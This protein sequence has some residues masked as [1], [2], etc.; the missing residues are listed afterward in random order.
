MKKSR[1]RK[2]EEDA[3]FIVTACNMHEELVEAL[4]GC[5]AA[6]SES[7]K[8]LRLC[9]ESG[10]ALVAKRHKDVAEALLAKLQA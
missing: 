8:Q 2:A 1:K 5:S 10:H 7:A 4:K 6:L 3:A 9:G